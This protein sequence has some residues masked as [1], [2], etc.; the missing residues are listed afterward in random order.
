MESC[1]SPAYNYCTHN[2]THLPTRTI[3]DG[4]QTTCYNRLAE[5][6]ASFSLWCF[7]DSGSYSDLFGNQI[8]TALI[9]K[10]S[11]Y[12]LDKEH[13][14]VGRSVEHNIHSWSIRITR[15]YA[16]N[17]QSRKWFCKDSE[18]IT[19]HNKQMV[20]QDHKNMM[21][22]PYRRVSQMPDFLKSSPAR[23]FSQPFWP[24]SYKKAKKFQKSY[25]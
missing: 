15:Q 11:G 16:K 21:D 20:W 13:A 22:G 23:S 5:E 8:L 14:N 25:A 12:G 17:S 7:K 10:W 19:K 24:K 4:D 9:C 3:S 1:L 18:V 2:L 6:N